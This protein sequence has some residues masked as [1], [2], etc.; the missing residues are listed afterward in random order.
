MSPEKKEDLTCAFHKDFESTLIRIEEK[1]DNVQGSINEL[2]EWRAGI[3]GAA[4]TVSVIVSFVISIL[5]IFLKS[6]LFPGNV[7]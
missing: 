1:L 7:K 6:I 2:R 5:V 4:A 3:K